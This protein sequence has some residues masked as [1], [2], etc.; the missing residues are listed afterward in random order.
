MNRAPAR[1]AVRR[2]FSDEDQAEIQAS[3]LLV[4]WRARGIHVR[5]YELGGVMRFERVAEVVDLDAARER[6]G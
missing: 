3:A 1:P 6:E 4:A 2:E 5:A